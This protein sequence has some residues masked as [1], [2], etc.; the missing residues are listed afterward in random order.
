MYLFNVQKYFFSYTITCKL[1]KSFF[2]VL[3][4]MQYLNPYILKCPE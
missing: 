1:A 2:L 3:E 4:K